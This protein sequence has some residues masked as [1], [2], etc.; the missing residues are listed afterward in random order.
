MTFLSQ[1]RDSDCFLRCI[2]ISYSTRP[3]LIPK[4]EPF[5]QRLI[6]SRRAGGGKA[7]GAER[8]LPGKTAFSDHRTN[9]IRRAERGLAEADVR[10]NEPPAV[11]R[12]FFLDQTFKQTAAFVRIA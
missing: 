3:R 2:K 10:S 11:S 9:Y 7:F 12:A 6:G 8:P 5:G 4:R 1:S